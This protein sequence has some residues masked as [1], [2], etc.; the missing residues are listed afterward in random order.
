MYH[1]IAIFTV[2]VWGATFISTKVLM[3]AG[4]TPIEVMFYRF[5]I[6]YISILPFTY[7][8]LFAASLKDEG[9]MLLIGLSG[10][11]LYFLAENYALSYTLASNVSLIICT[12]PILTALLDRFFGSRKS[13]T[14]H[15]LLGS[16]IAFIGIAF[17]IFNGSIVL[18]LN[19]IG[20]ILTLTAAFL[21][22]IFSLTLKKVQSQY[23]SLFITRKTFFYSILSLLPFIFFSPTHTSFSTLLRPIMFSNLLFLGLLAST[24]CFFLW[25]VAVKSIGP[26]SATNYIYFSPIVTLIVAH[27][28]LDEPITAMAIFGSFFI[29]VGVF[30]ALRKQKSF[31]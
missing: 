6:A 9:T 27:Y 5:V 18:G 26:V 21:W 20:D 12:T 8:R 31:A 16:T 2:I 19:P 15:F 13:L 24:L 29:V 1:L 30:L 7:K 14:P 4:L 25:N 3:S 11:S 17:V 10:G 28:V 22:G 23:K